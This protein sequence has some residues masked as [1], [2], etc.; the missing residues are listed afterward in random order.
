MSPS[1]DLT[2]TL[3]GLAI[4]GGLAITGFRNHFAEK[5]SIRPHRPPWMIISL[6]S[7]AMAFMILVHLANLL[8]F[9]T[10]NR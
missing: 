10:G 2:L 3:I 5:P 9:E 8:G 7:I 6:G 4:F 1:Q